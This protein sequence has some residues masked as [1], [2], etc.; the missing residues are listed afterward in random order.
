MNKLTIHYNS[1][2]ESGNIFW[3]LCALRN[4]LEYA[5]ESP[6]IYKNMQERVFASC[7]YKEA[8]N[9]I[10][11]KVNLIDINTEATSFNHE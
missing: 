1:K 9:I 10:G 8:L 5:G 4:A 2:G 11:E 3:I 6:A 7:S